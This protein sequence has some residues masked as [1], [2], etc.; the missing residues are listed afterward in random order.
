MINDFMDLIPGG[1]I[2]A[3]AL[4]S[5]GA[6]A[7]Y[8]YYQLWRMERR[9]RGMHL[10]LAEVATGVTKLVVKRDGEVNIITVEKS[11]GE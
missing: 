5:V 11:R 6:Y 3:L 2:T 1:G 10:L 8:L 9:M 4:I 7:G